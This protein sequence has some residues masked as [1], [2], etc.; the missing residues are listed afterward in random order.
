MISKSNI[1]ILDLNL[2]IASSTSD[3]NLILFDP[4]K[5]GDVNMYYNVNLVEPSGNSLRS[6]AVSMPKLITR[7]IQARTS[8][9]KT[10]GKISTLAELQKFFKTFFNFG[11][12]NHGS[13]I[14]RS[15]WTV[16]V[17]AGW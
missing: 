2:G 6:G 12:L 13:A 9:Q 11:L 15:W 7:K 17:Y 4:T 8:I 10:V 16:V 1:L 5:P 14:V 3:V